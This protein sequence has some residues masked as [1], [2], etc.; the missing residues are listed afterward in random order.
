MGFQQGLS[1]LNGAAKNLDVI[2]HNIANTSTVGFKASQAQFADVYATSLY[3]VG[4]LQVGIGTK[5]ANVAQSFTQGNISATG[6]TLDLAITGEGFF[7][8]NSGGVVSGSTVANGITSYTRNGQFH[9]DGDGYLVDNSGAYLTGYAATQGV[10]DPTKTSGDVLQVSYANGLASA[11][12]GV[13][14]DGVK[15]VV[16]LD[17]AGTP[18]AA[19]FDPGPPPSG[20]NHTTSVTVYD[21][22]GDEHTLSLYF[23][24]TSIA[25]SPTATWDMWAAMDGNM[26][27]AA[28]PLEF[29][30]VD[31]L[32]VSGALTTLTGTYTKGGG[33]GTDFNI[34]LNLSG[35]TM[36]AGKFGVNSLTQNGYA[37]GQL[38]GLSVSKDGLIE[39]QY[40]NGHPL[41]I[42]QLSLTSFNNPNGLLSIGDNHWI[43]TPDA[44]T[45][46]TQQPNSGVLGQIQSGAVEESNV[47][48]TAE[49]VNMIVAQRM[50]Q[51][52]AQTI[53][54]QDQILQTLVNLR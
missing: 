10:L 49:L 15:M 28:S 16:N 5:V 18:P 44:G 2:G 1:G 14:V 47:D 11:T 54:T 6:N 24:D 25:G 32:M 35:S 45:A 9:L 12:G 13:G 23:T 21:G 37:Q 3:G 20:F 40:T 41:T 39:A 19:A 50:Y 31:G 33:D 42:G 7:Q 52:N 27:A 43:S 46:N 34:D 29:S 8:V 17:A 4:G 38:A 53:K 30:R 22:V 48:L 51:A 26:S 36:F